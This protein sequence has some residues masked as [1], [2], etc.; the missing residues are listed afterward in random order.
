MKQTYEI[1]ADGV[2]KCRGEAVFNVSHQHA[3]L[4]DTGVADDQNLEQSFTEN[5]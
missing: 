3:R 5:S 1:D 2:V 4:T